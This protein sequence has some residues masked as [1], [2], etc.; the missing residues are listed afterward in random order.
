MRKICV[1]ITARTS[2]TKIKPILYHLNKKKSIKLQIVLAA[3]AVLDKYGKVDDIVKKDGFPVDE[4]I[5]ML[6]E[7]ESLLN[8]SKSTGIGIIEFSS[9]FNRLKPDLVLVMADRF[10]VISAAISAAYQNIPLAH[11]QGGE[12]SGNIDEKVRHAISKLADYHFPSTL[13]SKKW[14]IKM[15]ENSENVFHTGCPSIDIA[16]NIIKNPEINFNLYEKY[17]GVG[18]FPS[19]KNKYLIVMQHP[20]TTEYKQA[21]F[22]ILETLEAIKSIK[23]SVFWFWPNPDAGG[24]S[25]S[26]TI[27]RF[28]ENNKSTHLH[29]IKNMIPDDFL[30]FLYNSDGIIGNSSCAIRECSFLGIPSVNIGTRQSNRE[31]GPNTIDVNYNSNEIKNAIIEH[32]NGRVKGVNLYGNGNAGKQIADICSKIKLSFSKSLNYNNE[33]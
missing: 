29:F 11:I 23:K 18:D 13:R 24:D 12:V 7:S 9:A 16:K 19:L 20:V 30:R 25:T 8:T 10:E 15:G 28:R 21:E 32:C 1:V 3:S 31:R 17:G 22:Q 2:Y 4:K 14:L 27:R 33:K 26:K 6:I 5:Y